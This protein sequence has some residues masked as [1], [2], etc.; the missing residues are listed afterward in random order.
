MEPPYREKG[1]ARALLDAIRADMGELGEERLY[2][3]TDHKGFY[4]SCGWEFLAL[5][6]DLEGRPE[7][8]YTAKTH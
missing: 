7:R 4:E 5:V 3:V 1:L 8:M 6:S 2:L